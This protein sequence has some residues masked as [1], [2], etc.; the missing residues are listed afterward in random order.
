MSDPL[1]IEEWMSP[2][3]KLAR[4]RNSAPPPE[5][6]PRPYQVRVE[7]TDEEHTELAAL[8]LNERMTRFRQIQAERGTRQ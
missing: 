5:K 7:L 2:S 6:A 1:I 8:P 4:F 3:E